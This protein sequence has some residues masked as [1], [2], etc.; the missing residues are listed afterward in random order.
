MCI[1]IYILKRLY[2]KARKVIAMRNARKINVWIQ[3]GSYSNAS[4][5]MLP[6]HTYRFNVIRH[7]SIQTNSD[8][9]RTKHNPG[10]ICE[11]VVASILLNSNINP[12]PFVEENTHKRFTFSFNY[13]GH[14]WKDKFSGAYLPHARHS[15]TIRISIEHF[16][17]VKYVFSSRRVAVGWFC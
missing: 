13:K 1:C 4:L 6:C 2:E 7:I 12:I 9:F 5:S 3:F 16:D 14:W 15:Y 17:E 10:H 8:I 11:F